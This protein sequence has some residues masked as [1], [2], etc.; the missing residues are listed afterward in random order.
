MRTL[1]YCE[2][3]FSTGDGDLAVL[4]AS[5]LFQPSL[6][7]VSLGL[8]QRFDPDWYLQEIINSLSLVTHRIERLSLWMCMLSFVNVSVS[9]SGV[10]Y[11]LVRGELV[12]E[13]TTEYL[14]D[15]RVLVV[16]DHRRLLIPKNG[17]DEPPLV[18]QAGA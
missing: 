6:K 2:D 4:P 14:D 18:S 7:T 9:Q 1:S 3:L 5:T 17:D 8:A 16:H 15:L 10:S 13:H 11:R 12:V